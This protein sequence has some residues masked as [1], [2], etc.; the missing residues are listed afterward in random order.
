VLLILLAVI[1]ILIAVAF[2]VGASIISGNKGQLEDS[3]LIH[4]GDVAEGVAIVLG[5][6]SLGFGLVKL[7]AGIQVLKPKNG[8]RVTGIVFA[9]LGAAFW[10]IA[11]L[12]SLN[13][14]DTNGVRDTGT[15]VGGVILSLALLTLN[16]V[17][18]VLLG[19]AGEYFHG[20]AYQPLPQQAYQQPYQQPGPFST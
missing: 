16:V 7:I 6:I 17:V 11:L 2:F 8:W 14:N 4:L 9:S 19:R 5:V 18:I 1:P 13:P 20:R 12:G 3:R 15:N 10:V